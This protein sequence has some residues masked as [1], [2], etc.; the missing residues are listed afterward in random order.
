[1]STLQQDHQS[2]PADAQPAVID[3]VVAIHSYT[4]TEPTCLSFRKNEIIYVLSVDSSG[5]WDGLCNNLH[6]WFPSN[7]V[8]S[9]KRPDG[10]YPPEIE[11]TFATII[12][13]FDEEEDGM[14]DPEEDEEEEE[15]DDDDHFLEGGGRIGD[16]SSMHSSSTR[17]SVIQNDNSMDASAGSSPSRAA[18]LQKIADSASNAEANLPAN[19]RRKTTTDGQLYFYNVATNATAWTL[20]SVTRD[21]EQQPVKGDDGEPRLRKNSNLLNTLSTQ[22]PPMSEMSCKLNTWEGLINNILRAISELNK[23]AKQSDKGQFVM[24]TNDVVGAVRAMLLASG[25]SKSSPYL[26]NNVTLRSHHHQ[27]LSALAKLVLAS[28]VASGIWPPPDAVNKMRMQAGQVLLAIRHFVS[29]AQDNQIVLRLQP[30]S[31][32]REVDLD[33]QG[34]HFND[35]EMVSRLDQQA[36]LI[37]SGIDTIIEQTSQATRSNPALIDQTREVVNHVGQLLSLIEDIQISQVIEAEVATL[38]AEFKTK[39]EALYGNVNDLVTAGR[40]VMDHFAPPNAVRILRQSAAAVRRA[41]EDLLMS[42]K[43]LIEQKEQLEQVRLQVEVAELDGLK[44]DS[45]LSVLQRRAM[46]LNFLPN[47]PILPESPTVS[48]VASGNGEDGN[49]STD[50]ESPSDVKHKVAN[51]VIIDLPSA[52]DLLSTRSAP[53]PPHSAPLLAPTPTYGG[54]QGSLQSSPS[55]PNSKED[56]RKLQPYSTTKLPPRS[57]SDNNK[58]PDAKRQL[59]TLSGHPRTGKGAFMSLSEQGSGSSIDSSKLSKFF[60]IDAGTAS[61]QNQDHWFLDHDY[62]VNDIKFNME[63]NISGGTLEALVELLT[64][65]DSTPDSEYTHAFLLTFHQFTTPRRFL[66]LLIQRFCMLP[67]AELT[68]DTEEYQTWYDMKL[69]IVR[70]RVVNALK[71]WLTSYYVE[72]HDDAVLDDIQSFCETT[73]RE[74]NSQWAVRILEAVDKRISQVGHMLNPKPAHVKVSERPPEAPIR[75][76]MGFKKATLQDINPQE[77]ARQLTLL[78]LKHFL[79]VQPCEL[80]NQEWSKKERNNAPN[81]KA[82]VALSTQISGWVVETIL[83]ERE[84]K[85]RAGWIKYWIKVADKTR[86]INNYNLLMAL[87]SGLDSS[88]VARLRKTWEFVS[89]KT[90]ATMQRV[91][92]AI[93]DSNSRNYTNYRNMI[94]TSVPPCIPFLGFYLTDLTFTD[95]GNPQFRAGNPNMI[96]FYRFGRVAHLIK[97]LLRFQE[98]YPFAEIADVQGMISDQLA[99]CKVKG[100]ADELHRMSLLLE[101]RFSIFLSDAVVVDQYVYQLWLTGYTAYRLEQYKSP[102]VSATGAKQTRSEIIAMLQG[103][104]SRASSQFSSLSDLYKS[105]NASSKAEQEERRSAHDVAKSSVERV[106]EQPSTSRESVGK[107][108]ATAPVELSRAPSQ[109]SILCKGSTAASI[110]PSEAI[111]RNYILSQYRSFEL[112]EHYLH[113]PRYFSTQFYF[114]LKREMMQAIVERYYLF[115]ESVMRELLGK[116]LNSRSRKDLDDVADRTGVP[117]GSCRRQFDNVKRVMK[118]VEDIAG[119]VATILHTEFLLRY[120]CI[121]FINNLRLDTQ[122]RKL[123]LFTFADFEYCAAVFMKHWTPTSA[124][125]QTTDDIDEMIAQDAREVRAVFLA[126][127]DLLDE[128]RSVVTRQLSASTDPT[129]PATVSS[130]SDQIQTQFRTLVRNV[131]SIGAG[132]SQSKEMKDIFIDLVEKVVEPCIAMGWTQPDVDA[133]FQALISQ[134]G[135]LTSLQDNYKSRYHPSFARL[136]TGVQLASSRLFGRLKSK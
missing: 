84:P 34:A 99:K 102:K 91:R 11:A 60:G 104:L 121:N 56:V 103:S 114:S 125:S 130:S 77:L 94:K 89:S 116:K 30:D 81:I 75:P 74:V 13:P 27:L 23:A 136:L 32:R 105:K 4:A 72:E 19:W 127:K 65:H 47:A 54:E 7:F 21:A 14:G 67:P 79:Q 18:A 66:D 126:S 8:K 83:S 53:T 80:L 95:E 82:M 71:N 61:K 69:K 59:G 88:P 134:F 12:M 73:M 109:S 112:M 107:Q 135:T 118:R 6:G 35:V 92:D 3:V 50:G 26:K 133:F 110:A 49:A 64:I 78:E 25:I 62:G 129:S 20:D 86:E 17:S 40:T 39:R 15:E 43:L 111:M 128:Y 16:R 117:L 44:R 46:S 2:P 38:V 37:V 22:L 98:P 70:S 36:L 115:D 106:D 45:D 63:G 51:L 113:N 119:D 90:R 93:F 33:L 97:D 131:L 101:P 108:S 120:A 31:Q 87:L 52:P 28:K 48:S 24:H 123:N 85:K 100:N 42:A 10:T 41:V 58:S 55:R 132:L 5:W 76:R 96:N 68:P 1:M 122:K 57:S 124:G 9:L 29:V